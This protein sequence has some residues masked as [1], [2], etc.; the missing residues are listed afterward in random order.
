MKSGCAKTGSIIAVLAVNPATCRPNIRW[1]S[2]IAG[3]AL[4]WEQICVTSRGRS[5]FRF[6]E[7]RCL[8]LIHPKQ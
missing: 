8:A 7:Y 6:M 4:K 3:I 5:V 2:E 1:R